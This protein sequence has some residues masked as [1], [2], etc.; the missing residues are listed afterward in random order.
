MPG[1]KPAEFA[2]HDAQFFPIFSGAHNGEWT[3]CTECHSNPANYSV[4]TCID[5][6]E[7]NR[8]DMDDKHSGENGYE[9]SSLA[10][11]DCHPTGS[12]E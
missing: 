9:Y 6:H 11:L 3:S 5:C 8:T 1:W 12:H 10:C 4:F 2:I 7:H